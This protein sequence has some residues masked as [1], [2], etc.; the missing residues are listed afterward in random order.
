LYILQKHKND[1]VVINKELKNGELNI[2]WIL[3]RNG[4]F[5]MNM[6]IDDFKKEMK[7]CKKNNKRFI[8]IPLSL[9]GHHNML[10]I[11]LEKKSL[12]WFEP[13]GVA[14]KQ[15]RKNVKRT[16]KGII[17]LRKICD[18]LG[19]SLITP[20]EICPRISKDKLKEI[21]EINISRYREDK[22]EN[23]KIKIGLQ[24]IESKSSNIIDDQ[25]GFCTAWSYYY[26]D[27]R[28]TY[29]DIEPRKLQE[30]LFELLNY[31]VKNFGLFIRN[32]S[33][34]LI[35]I[36][37]KIYDDFY[38][39]NPDVQKYRL[40]FGSTIN[41]N[42]LIITNPKLKIELEK[43]KNEFDKYL[44]S[45]FLEVAGNNR[46]VISQKDIDKFFNM[47]IDVKPEIEEKI[48]LKPKKKEK[49]K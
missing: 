38:I 6:S 25:S 41:V 42:K 1:C 22:F 7:K 24:S 43:V 4:E 17:N 12:E 8:S 30:K 44:L 32:Y 49:K 46:L 28:L 45:L 36:T 33:K 19:L 11:D 39:K 31:N 27:S 18:S 29:P 10:L 3:L 34:F 21:K 13:H 5:S 2:E 35:Q 26:L 23:D 40:I 48:E 20:E 37:A 47:K 16:E 14:Y 9:R 15:G